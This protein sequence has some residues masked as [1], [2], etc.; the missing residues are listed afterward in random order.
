MTAAAPKPKPTSIP[1]KRAA[2]N[3]LK[4]TESDYSPEHFHTRA[5]NKH[6]H[7]KSIQTPFPSDMHSQI[8]RW[9]RLIPEYKD[10]AQAMIRDAVHHRLHW[11]KEN[12]DGG[13]VSAIYEA[14]AEAQRVYEHELMI[15]ELIEE[16]RKEVL[17]LVKKGKRKALGAVLDVY[18]PLLLDLE[19]TERAELQEIIALAEESM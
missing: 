1:G 8:H 12:K 15:S 6:D 9:S 18:R 16:A 13:E 11:L 2:V 17:F 19:P 10:S 7:S 3:P 14:R 5:T 4:L